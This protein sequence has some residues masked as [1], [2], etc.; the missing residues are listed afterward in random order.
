MSAERQGPDFRYEPAM[1]SPPPP[2]RV[3]QIIVIAAVVAAVI[4][5]LRS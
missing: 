5:W 2:L 4:D 1:Y 3:W